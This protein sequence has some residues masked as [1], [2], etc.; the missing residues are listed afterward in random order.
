MLVRQKSS[1]DVICGLDMLVLCGNVVSCCNLCLTICIA[2]RTGTSPPLMSRLSSPL[3]QSFLQYKLSNKG[4]NR[5]LHYH[6]EPTCAYH[7]LHPY[8]SSASPTLTSSS[9]AYIGES[10][11]SLG[12][13]VKEHFKAPSPIHLHSTTTGHPMDS[14][15]FNIEHKEVNSH[16]RTIKKA[17]FICIQDPTLNRNLGKYQ[18]LHIWDHL[19]QLSPTLQLKPGSSLPYTTHLNT[20][21]NK[22]PSCYPYRWGHILVL[23]SIKCLG[24]IPP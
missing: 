17:M 4:Y 16:S 13:R 7:K 1:R 3:Y 19:L 9:S 21:L 23:E 18:L 5:T 8:W 15:Q 2:G 24:L 20:P 11:R 14:E 22:S 12:D 10:G 6:K